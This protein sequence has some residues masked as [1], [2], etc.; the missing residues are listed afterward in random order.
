[1]AVIVKQVTVTFTELSIPI[2][3]LTPKI[4]IV[5]Y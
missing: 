5:Y 1:M 4:S 3:T 2:D